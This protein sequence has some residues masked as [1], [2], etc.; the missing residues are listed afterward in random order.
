MVSYGISWYLWYLMVF[1]CISLHLLRS[2]GHLLRKNFGGSYRAHTGRIQGT[3]RVHTGHL[4]G[5]YRILQGAY[6]S[7]TGHLQGTYGVHTGTY[8]DLT[9]RLQG[10][11]EHLQFA[12]RANTMHRNGRVAAVEPRSGESTREAR[13]IMR[14]ATPSEAR[15]SGE[16]CKKP[17]RVAAR[18]V[19][20]EAAHIGPRSGPQ[21]RASESSIPV[22]IFK[23][24]LNKIFKG[25][26][27]LLMHAKS[28]ANF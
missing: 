14:A 1:Y 9:G 26:V 19:G 15:R 8:G 25:L 13:H 7:S 4:Q 20:R 27:I 24:N 6:R 3:Y 22:L 23:S 11:T 5:R 16:R 17:S 10:H 12:Y 21:D 2:T 18:S 28:H